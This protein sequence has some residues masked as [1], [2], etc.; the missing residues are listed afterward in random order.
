MVSIPSKAVE[1]AASMEAA[2]TVM[3]AF[4]G[5]YLG[6]TFSQQG[7]LSGWQFLGLASLLLFTCC[8][9][10]F[11]KLA[12]DK[13]GKDP[14][15]VALHLFLAFC[16]GVT[17]VI[18]AHWMGIAPHILAICFLIWWFVAVGVEGTRILMKHG[19]GL[20]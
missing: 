20:R 12:H 10:V 3:G 8:F 1:R 14:K 2:N 7:A 9:V 19:S 16:S 15:S 6:L 17:A 18:D 5:A 13:F 11:I 4:L